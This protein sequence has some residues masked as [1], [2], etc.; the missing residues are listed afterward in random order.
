MINYIIEVRESWDFIDIFEN[1]KLAEE[2][3]EDF[4]KEDWERNNCYS[5]Y[6]VENYWKENETREFKS[7]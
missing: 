1:L 2:V 3:I 4:E 6:K 5:I 7:N